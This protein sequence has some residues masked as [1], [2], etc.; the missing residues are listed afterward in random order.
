MQFA[1]HMLMWH[2]PLNVPSWLQVQLVKPMASRLLQ[3]QR[4][5][6]HRAACQIMMMVV[7]VILIRVMTVTGIATTPGPAAR[8]TSHQARPAAHQST[9][10]VWCL[11][12]VCSCCV[13][14]ASLPPCFAPQCVLLPLLFATS[15]C[16]G[17]PGRIISTQRSKPHGPAAWHPG[18]MPHPCTSIK[19]VMAGSAAAAAATRC[20]C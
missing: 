20:Q 16:C 4:Q 3:E 13:M 5:P 18:P 7:M 10:P 1:S 17:P 19:L 15:S 9:W 6:S 8:A 12:C 14:N 2:P 11:R